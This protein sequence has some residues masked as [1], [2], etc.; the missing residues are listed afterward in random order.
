ME[1]RVCAIV[2]DIPPHAEVME[3]VAGYD[4]GFKVGDVDGLRRSIE[5]ALTN[6]NHAMSLASRMRA[7]VRKHY[8]WPTLA[9]ATERLYR[10]VLARPA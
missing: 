10:E 4:L 8:S 9:A 2:S 3:G 5:R 6:E 7:H 1:R